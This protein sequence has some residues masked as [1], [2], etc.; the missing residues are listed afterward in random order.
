MRTHLARPAEGRPPEPVTPPPT[1]PV[2][3]AAA[4]TDRALLRIGAVSGLAG[5]VVEV[6]MNVLHP[7]H[8]DPNDSRAAFEE[9]SHSTHWTDIHLG[10]F[11]GTLLIALSLV[12]LA[13]ALSRQRGLPG[14][15]AVVGAV[16]T[17]V[18]A[19]VFAVQMAVDGVALRSSIDTW[20]SATGAE[21]TSAFQ[22]A[23]GVRDLEKALS[24]LFHLNNG[25][26]LLALGLSVALGHL[27]ARWLGW[28]GVLAGLAFLVGGVV[29][30]HTGFSA[31]SGAFLTPALVL[32]VV[33]LTGSCISMWRRAAISW[34]ITPGQDGEG[35]A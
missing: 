18:L 14:A 12:A 27:Y 35:P 11:L 29:T 3:D 32:M 16:T 2:A 28:V 17:I 23:E 30:G 31:E 10:Q 13:R 25:F 6:V 5:L 22:V 26:T 15:L 4:A 21:K 33:F 24:A 8:A 34:S 7:A 20:A 19:S 9:Y 1:S